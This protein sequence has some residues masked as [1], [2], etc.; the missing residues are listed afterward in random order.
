MEKDSQ[1]SLLVQFLNPWCI[2]I[3]YLSNANNI[4]HFDAFV[5]LY[6]DVKKIRRKDTLVEVLALPSILSNGKHLKPQAVVRQ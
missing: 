2:T 5:V 4:P 1:V 6:Q 3:E